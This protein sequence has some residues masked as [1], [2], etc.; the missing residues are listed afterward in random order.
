MLVGNGFDGQHFQSVH[1]RRLTSPPR[2]DCPSPFARR[3][4]F[5]AEVIGTTICD[6]FLRR[7]IGREVR[8]SITSWGGP[9]VL[10]EGVFGNAHS[11]L[12]VASLPVDKSNTNSTV[13]VFAKKKRS[14][15]ING[16]NLKIRRGFTKAFLQYDI[17]KLAG[18]RYQPEGLTEQDLE[19]TDF[20]VWAAALPK[21]VD[22]DWQ[23]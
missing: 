18:V 21:V 1:D 9:H 3:M 15:L 14:R 13:I 6:R 10:V 17:D 22:K 12:L 5:E 4:R 20:F 11:R 8:I 2:V 7:F 19:L 16:I 23:D